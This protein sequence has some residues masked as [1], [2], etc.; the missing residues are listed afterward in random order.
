MDWKTELARI[1]KIYV[2]NPAKQAA[3]TSVCD[4]ISNAYS[5][6]ALAYQN[7]E[8]TIIDAFRDLYAT[9]FLMEPPRSNSSPLTR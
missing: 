1:D 2:A 5:T 3:L 4:W 8:K 9:D 6:N 7:R